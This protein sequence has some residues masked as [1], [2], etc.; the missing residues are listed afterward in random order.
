MSLLK[1]L[2][3]RKGD[4]GYKGMSRSSIIIIIYIKRT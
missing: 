3:M 4:Y 2:T 1:R